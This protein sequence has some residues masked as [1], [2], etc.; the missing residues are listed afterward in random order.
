MLNPGYCSIKFRLLSL[1]SVF[2]KWH[3]MYAIVDIAGKQYK[4]ENKQT[5]Y[6]NKLEGKEGSK[7]E[8]DKVLFIEKDG[9]AQIGTP[10]LKGSKVTG[11]IEAHVKGD[12][13]VVFK[14]KRRKGYQVKNGHR[15]DFTQVLIEGIK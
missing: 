2:Q 9:K 4:V 14:K 6:T 7:V 11:K 13:V 3:N 1:H 15:Q 12:K 10:T 5:I 8:F